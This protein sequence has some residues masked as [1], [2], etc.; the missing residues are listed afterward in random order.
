MPDHP[1]EAC[2]RPAPDS[3]IC[4]SCVNDLVTEIASVSAYR[5]LAFDLDISISKQSKFRAPAGGSTS[6]D[7]R[8]MPMDEK[9]SDVARH[10][11]ATLAKWAQV[12]ITETGADQP[13]DDLPGIAAWLRTRVRWL[14]HHADAAKAHN[15]IRDAVRAARVAV[16]RPSD[17]VYAG[18]CDCG[19][20]LYAY[21]GKR[22]AECRAEEHPEPLMWPVDERREWLLQQATDYIGT[23]TEISAALS[24]LAKPV[25]PAAI[26]GY[27]H[28]GSLKP[29]W[30]DARGRAMYRL[31]DVLTVVAPPAVGQ[32][33]A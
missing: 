33:A 13:A 31:G 2:G 26:R 19:R 6:T 24:R 28:R 29:I 5:G 16:D 25:T 23:T 11:K 32:E 14:A 12:I 9:A 10:L 1:C 8:P 4:S 7:E 15:E 27:T 18:P 17:R 3:T 30:A 22:W 20:D 21:P